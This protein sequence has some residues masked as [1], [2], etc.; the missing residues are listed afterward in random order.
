MITRTILAAVAAM[1]MSVSAHAQI[2]PASSGEPSFNEPEMHKH[3]SGL[4]HPRRPHH[5]RHS[6]L[7][8][9]GR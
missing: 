1:V 5:R 7:R 9:R 8:H 2:K 4:Y 3:G 6:R